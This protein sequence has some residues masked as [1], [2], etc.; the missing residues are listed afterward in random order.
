MISALTLVELKHVTLL[1]CP[2]KLFLK[3]QNTKV[4]LKDSYFH[5]AVMRTLQKCG[6]DTTG[7]DFKRPYLEINYYYISPPQKKKSVN[8]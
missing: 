4:F 2:I 8:Q 7:Y 5:V 6:R 1:Y 3:N